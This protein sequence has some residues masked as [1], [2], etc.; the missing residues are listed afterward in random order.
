MPSSTC[1]VPGT[2][3]L[4][5]S[6]RPRCQKFPPPLMPTSLEASIADEKSTGLA[7]GPVISLN[8]HLMGLM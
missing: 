7:Y 8:L 4:H 6:P 3:H 1:Y 2:V 5:G